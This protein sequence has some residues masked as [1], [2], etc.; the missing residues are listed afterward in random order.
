MNVMSRTMKFFMIRLNIKMTAIDT[1][2]P[3]NIAYADKSV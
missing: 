2:K 3:N 1:I